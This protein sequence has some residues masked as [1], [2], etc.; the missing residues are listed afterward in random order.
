[1]VSYLWNGYRLQH[2]RSSAVC[3]FFTSHC[4]GLCF[5]NFMAKMCV[6]VAGEQAGV[7]V[8][9]LCTLLN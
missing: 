1:M 5:V 8:K 7:V 4:C 6:C 2:C 3:F 9:T